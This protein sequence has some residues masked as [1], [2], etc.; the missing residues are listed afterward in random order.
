MPPAS[1]GFWSNIAEIS[2]Q[3]S[4]LGHETDEGFSSFLRG[5]RD[6]CRVPVWNDQLPFLFSIGLTYSIPP[7]LCAAVT[8]LVKL[9]VLHSFSILYYVLRKNT[10]LGFCHKNVDNKKIIDKP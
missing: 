9:F 5:C 10:T 4:V 8:H 2:S 7:D 6:V 1:Q 3:P